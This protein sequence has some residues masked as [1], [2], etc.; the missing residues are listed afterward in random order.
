[1]FLTKD[2]NIKQFCNV[3][4]IYAMSRDIMVEYSIYILADLFQIR[5]IIKTECK[6]ED[7]EKFDDTFIRQK[8][9][10]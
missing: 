9:N 7:N 10:F 4:G 6:Y 1:M 2:E 3:F 5:E 8:Y